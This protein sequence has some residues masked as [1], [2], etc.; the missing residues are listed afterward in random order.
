MGGL[1]TAVI[2]VTLAVRPVLSHTGTIVTVEL[3]AQDCQT[4]VKAIQSQIHPKTN[5]QKTRD[6]PRLALQLWGSTAQ[7]RLCLSW[8][9]WVVRQSRR[10]F[11]STARR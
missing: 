10:S 7:W 9:S 8:V 6:Y 5:V 11:L 4:G 3:Q 2:W 1:Q